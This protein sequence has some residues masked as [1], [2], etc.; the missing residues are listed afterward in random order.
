MAVEAWAGLPGAVATNLRWI[1][2][3]VVSAGFYS[4]TLHE[5]GSIWAALGLAIIVFG[6]GIFLS[7]K[8]YRSLLG[9]SS[10]H[11]LQLAHANLA[12]YLLFVFAGFFVGFF[13]L[14]LPGILIRASGLIDL[15][16]DTDP[17]LIQQAFGDMMATPYGA[18][19]ILV[20]GLGALVLG[21]VAL[22]LS[23]FGAATVSTGKAQVF[24]SGGLTKGHVLPLAITS[25]ATHIL[26]FTA[27]IALNYALQPL[28]PVGPWGDFLR[29]AVGAILLIP[30][31]VVGHGYASAAWRRLSPQ[32]LANNSD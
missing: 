13:L 12:V 5:E 1:A 23:L 27:A 15:E 8:L 2:L 17:Q 29:G 32:P 20:C 26:P 6:A 31:L 30:F 7:L 14:I 4:I 11:F 24:Q 22:R 3:F 16:R 28:L 18:I 10:G 9:V 25:V 19:Y 21:L